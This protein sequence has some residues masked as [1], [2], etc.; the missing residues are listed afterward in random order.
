MSKSYSLRFS[1]KSFVA[2][3]MTKTC[4]QNGCSHWLPFMSKMKEFEL[5]WVVITFAHL[6]FAI[7]LFTIK[8][9][10]MLHGSSSMS[11]NPYTLGSSLIVL[12]NSSEFFLFVL[13]NFIPNVIWSKS[14]SIH[15]P[16]L[17]EFPV[18][19]LKS[20]LEFKH[21]QVHIK[22]ESFKCESKFMFISIRFEF[23]S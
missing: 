6:H 11:S 14:S 3:L 7:P 20:L 1:K 2:L 13:L 4:N 8:S 22:F 10:L 9:H 19:Q 16:P 17:Y 5:S 18:V 12:F 23:K 21:V 15:H